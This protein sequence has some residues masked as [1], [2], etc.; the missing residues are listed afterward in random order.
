MFAACFAKK[1]K[2]FLEVKAMNKHY[3]VDG[4]NYVVRYEGRKVY[5]GT[6]ALLSNM[7]SQMIVHE[8]MKPLHWKATGDFIDLIDAKGVRCIGVGYKVPIFTNPR[9]LEKVFQ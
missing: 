7:A 4:K 9:S 8:I 2:T 3:T 5:V 6:A 1:E